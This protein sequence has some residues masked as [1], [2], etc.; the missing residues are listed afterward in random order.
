MEKKRTDRPWIDAPRHG[1]EQSN[2]STP[3]LV[4]DGGQLVVKQQKK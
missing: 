2:F 1:R 4:A 3:M